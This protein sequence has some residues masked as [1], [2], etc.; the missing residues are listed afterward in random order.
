M[1][2]V[3]GLIICCS[4]V[5]GTPARADGAG[6]L[7][8]VLNAFI[9]AIA[10]DHPEF[11]T[12]IMPLGPGQEVKP[13]FQRGES[14]ILGVYSFRPKTW[15]ELNDGE[16]STILH[17]PNLKAFL[18]SIRGERIYPLVSAANDGVTPPP[19]WYP[20]EGAGAT[21]FVYRAR[22]APDEMLH[23]RAVQVPVLAA[24]NP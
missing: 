12:E 6:N 7:I 2:F 8:A 14:V 4:A 24:P 23:N 9:A 22:I 16:R 18:V 20:K 17:H 13:G 10:K 1:R 11:K 3:L 5:I 15:T 19:G 21:D